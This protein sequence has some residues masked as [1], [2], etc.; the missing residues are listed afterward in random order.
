MNELSGIKT[1]IRREEETTERLGAQSTL[2]N[3]QRDALE[4]ALKELR[5]EE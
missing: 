5:E 2:I 3:K 4:L 1:E